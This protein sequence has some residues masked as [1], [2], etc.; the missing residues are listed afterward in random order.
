MNVGAN[1]PG[2]AGASGRPTGIQ[3]I[4]GGSVGQMAKAPIVNSD[5]NV[6]VNSD[7][8]VTVNVVKDP[9]GILIRATGNIDVN[10]SRIATFGGGDIR[11]TSL[12]GNI[13]AGSG[14]K[15]EQAQFAVDVP[16]VDSQGRPVID[17]TTGVQKLKRTVYEVPGSGIFTFHPN[18]PQP[19]V[20]PTFNDPQINALL[21]EAD[22]QGFLGRDVS[23]LVARANQLK[24]KL[25]PRF[26]QT[27]LNP[28]VDKLKL[29][30]ITL[31]V[32][33][34]NIIIP[35]AGIRGRDITLIAPHG[36]VDFRGGALIG[37]V[38]RANFP[39]VVG[40]PN[41]PV[42]SPPGVGPP[43][44]PLSGGGVVGAV[45]TTAVASSS[46]A[47]SAESVQETVAETS[48]QS[49]RAKQV[50]SKRDDDKDG[51]SQLEKSVRVKRGVVIQVDVKRAVKPRKE[52]RE[53]I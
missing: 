30:N 25:E 15:N 24:A 19:L 14:S 20:F 49:S 46:A 18:D 51:K 27:V 10:K 3:V 37:R 48:G 1:S 12:Q 32:E 28:F 13:N 52:S 22:R 29:G 42:L 17:P 6:I 36:V 53:W 33:R 45:S 39:V 7:G 35:P 16:E 47:K 44:P 26:N 34:G 41:I 40:T 43:P 4:Q 11:L 2:S 31:T 23:Q 38:D 9:A 8:T 50:A 5:G 21:A